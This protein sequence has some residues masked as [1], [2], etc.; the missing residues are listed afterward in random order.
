MIR[1]LFRIRNLPSERKYKIRTI[2]RIAAYNYRF[3]NRASHAMVAIVLGAYLALPAREYG[4]FGIVRHRTAAA[5]LH[6]GNVQRFVAGIGEVVSK[7]HQ[8]ALLDRA[9]V[10][11]GVDPVYGRVIVGIRFVHTGFPCQAVH[12]KYLYLLGLVFS[13]ASK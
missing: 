11:R 10:Q 5:R 2:A 1:K 9:K 6:I 3:G 7:R 4:R 13:F 8:F 12:V